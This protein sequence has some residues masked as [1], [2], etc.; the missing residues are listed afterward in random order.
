ME[1]RNV[2]LVA[3]TLRPETMYGQTSCFV[4]PTGDYVAVEMKNDEVFICS[5][6]SAMNMAFQEYTKENEKIS[7][8]DHIKGTDLMGLPLSAPHAVHKVVYTLPMMTISM[9]KGTGVVTC[10]PSDSPDDWMAT[11]DLR[12]KKALREK[13]GITEEMVAP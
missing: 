13:F 4:L 3:A 8:I 9:K 11:Q 1:G 12:N 6:R 10:V 5:E 7:V 2:F